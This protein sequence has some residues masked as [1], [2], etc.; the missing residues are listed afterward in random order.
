MPHRAP[1]PAVSENEV[2]ISQALF[3]D[4]SAS[5]SDEEQNKQH[6]DRKARML[7]PEQIPNL[8]V[9]SESDD[10]GFIAETLAASNRKAANV[11]GRSVKKGGAFQGTL[12]TIQIFTIIL[13][14]TAKTSISNF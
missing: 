14:D 13:L 9:E 10:A 2:D 1:S 5:R 8:E 7:A 6:P 11:K 12:K 3:N 4:E